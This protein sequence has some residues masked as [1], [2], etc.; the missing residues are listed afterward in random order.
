M[1]ISLV[2]PVYNEIGTIAEILRRV[3][4]APFEKEIIIVDDG[5]KDGTRDYL[6]TLKDPNIRVILHEKNQGKGGALRTGF[7]YATGDIVVIQDADLEYYPDEIPFLVEK[8]SEGKADVVFGSRFKGSQRVFLFYHYLGNK[9]VNLIANILFNTNLSDFMTCYKAFRRE[10]IQSLQLSANG[11]DIEAEMTAKI[12]KKGFRVY[13]VPISYGGRSYDEGKKITWFDF[14]RVVGCLLK[15]RFADFESAEDPLEKVRSMRHYNRWIFD[16]LKPYLGEEVVEVGGGVG[17]FTPL[18]GRRKKL[19]VTEHKDYYL[20]RLKDRFVG[21]PFLKVEYLDLATPKTTPA[22]QSF[23]TALCLNV[24]EYIEDEQHALRNLKGLLRTGGRLL[25]LVPSDPEIFS[26]LDKKMGHHRRY[27]KADLEKLLQGAGFEIEKLYH[28][29][30][31]SVIPWFL[32]G[33]IFKRKVI[34]S[35]QSKTWD[36]CIPLVRLFSPKE[37]SFGLSLI[38]VARKK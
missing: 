17:N 26:H 15:A 1:K 32:N 24:L 22:G 4:A 13:E 34:P 2:V 25:L 37:P 23:D 36:W 38:A 5:S 16:E 35:F 27:R 29:D 8:I 18:L 21:H 30:P 9:F 14:F 7:Q 33:K 3:Q 12:F 10:I 19:V 31:V 11:F 6:A 20:S 28:F